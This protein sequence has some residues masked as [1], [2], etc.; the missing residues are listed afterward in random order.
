[1]LP[2]YH[3]G[4]KM[5]PIQLHHLARIDATMTVEIVMVIEEIKEVVRV[6]EVVNTSI[7]TVTKV[8]PVSP[9]LSLT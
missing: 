2:Y 9:V 6:V 8:R 4:D 7:G 5:W 3:E 1:M